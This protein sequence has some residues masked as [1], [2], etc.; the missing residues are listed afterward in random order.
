[1][2]SV[3]MVLAGALWFVGSGLLIG[4]R[5]A[6]N[7]GH[8]SRR[9]RNDPGRITA[10]VASWRKIIAVAGVCLL[11]SGGI[12]V[13]V[14]Y[15]RFQ[16]ARDAYVALREHLGLDPRL[17]PIR[18]DELFRNVWIGPPL[19]GAVSLA[20]A[21]LAC[22]VASRIERLLRWGIGA[23]W[24]RKM[25]VAGVCLLGLSGVLYHLVMSG[26]EWLNPLLFWFSLIAG[27]ACTVA[28][29]I[30]ERIDVSALLGARDNGVAD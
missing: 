25:A 9:E 1:M 7:R 4:E 6:R 29:V 13:V 3:E 18:L 21:G 17:P 19:I 23:K 16:R 26:E 14:G 28:A 2:P 10:R 12:L 30:A 11:V 22:V 20:A 15:H 5:V 27:I 24:A 8:L